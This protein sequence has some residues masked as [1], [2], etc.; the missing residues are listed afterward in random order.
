VHSG[1]DDNVLDYD[2]KGGSYPR[3]KSFD[4]SGAA[5]G[6]KEGEKESSK[7]ENGVMGKDVD[8]GQG[9]GISLEK[10]GTSAARTGS[11]YFI[12]RTGKEITLPSYEKRGGGDTPDHR[13][14]LSTA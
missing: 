5:A 13:Q 2:K 1:P 6:G 3:G 14:M 11:R 4:H 12:Q 8:C 10:R 9:G 7:K